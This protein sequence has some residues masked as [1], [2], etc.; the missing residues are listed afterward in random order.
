MPKKSYGN[1]K[2]P[3]KNTKSGGSKMGHKGISGAYG[4]KGSV[5]KK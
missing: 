2:R 4:K 1:V 3:V 5:R